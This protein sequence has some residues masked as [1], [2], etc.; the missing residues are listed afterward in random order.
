MIQDQ[1]S[2]QGRFKRYAHV[3]SSLSTT[4]FRFLGERFFGFSLDH[5][6]QAKSLAEA[7]GALKGPIMKVA[8]ILATIPDAVPLEYAQEFMHLQTD[9]PSMGWP[10]VKRR[11]VQEL[12]ADWA[13]KFRLFEKQASFA[14]S[15]GQ[16][17]KAQSEQGEWLACKLQYPDMSSIVEADL[18]QLK[19]IFRLYEVKASALKTE[20]IFEEISERMREE[21]DYQREA[22]H[23]MAYRHILKSAQQVYLPEVIP[24]LSTKRLL[25]MRWLEGKKLHYMLGESQ[26]FRNQ[27][28]KTMFH[29]W[30]TP[31]Y[32]YGFIHADPH[33]GNYTFRED[34]SVNLLD[35]GCIRIFPCRV[36]EG[37][38]DL[39]HSLRQDDQERLV[40]AY[41]SWGFN[42]LT[43]EVIGILNLWARLLYEPLL[44]DCVRPIQREFNGVNGR[45]TALK[46]HEELR[47]VGGIKPPREFV[48]LDRATVG[49]GSVFLH[50]KAQ[51]NWHQEFEKVI[52]NFD[53][54]EFTKRQERLL[55]CADLSA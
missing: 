50:L 47:R 33:L 25:T 45:N 48:Y 41:E 11:M 34:G 9:A 32:H 40:H 14:A 12:G 27:L 37:V 17:H 31:F 5:T 13:L 3:S 43:K 4:A 7:L 6:A 22:K 46:V 54:T 52:E 18:Q 53:P 15:L 20:E 24:E 28:A 35:F 44:E 1:D 51:L 8:Q 39:Y 2:R 19:L 38:L 26:D 10:F 23:I 21:L 30:Y 55:K 36:I 16:V 29:I 42:N 49:I